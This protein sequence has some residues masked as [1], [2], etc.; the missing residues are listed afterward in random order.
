MSLPSVRRTVAGM[1]LASSVFW[2]RS[3]VSGRLG[4]S[5]LSATSF[6]GMRFTCA[7]IPRRRRM[8][9]FAISGVSLTSRIMA[10]S[11]E[12]LLPVFSK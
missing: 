11:K 5:G 3:T 1:P 4:F 9:C 12:I 6:S 8:S 7:A 2:K 10:Y